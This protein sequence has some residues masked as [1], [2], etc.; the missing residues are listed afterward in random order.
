MSKLKAL[1]PAI[2]QEED[3]LD[4]NP[5]SS[6]DEDNNEKHSKLISDI[7]KLSSSKKRFLKCSTQAFIAHSRF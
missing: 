5:H 6:D 3:F 2:P 7:T 4:I 1:K